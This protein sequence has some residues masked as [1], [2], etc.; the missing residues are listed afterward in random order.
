LERDGRIRE[1]E[2]R[3]AALEERLRDVEGQLR[4]ARARLGTNATNSFV[5]PS[6][7]PP[8]APKPVTK[9]RTGNPSGGQPGHPARLRQRLPPPTWQ[10][11]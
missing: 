6:A 9:K 11:R 4:E 10:S 3:A 8:E 2:Q 5:P 7:N 1:L